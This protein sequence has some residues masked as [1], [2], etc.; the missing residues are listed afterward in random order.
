LGLR[1]GRKSK[2]HSQVGTWL[3]QNHSCTICPRIRNPEPFKPPFNRDRGLLA[4]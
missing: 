4:G 2:T 3:P 1:Q